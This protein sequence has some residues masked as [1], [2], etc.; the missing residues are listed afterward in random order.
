MIAKLIRNWIARHRN[1]T[2]LM[3]HAV[4]IPATI[5]AVPLAIMRHF[6]FAVGLFI[7]GYALQFLGHM[8]EGTPSGEGKLLRRILRR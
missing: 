5:A 3:L 2:N 6:L 1:R 4:G 8:L 7:A